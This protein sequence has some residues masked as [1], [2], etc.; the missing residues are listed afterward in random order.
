MT[1]N[2]YKIVLTAGRTL[3]SEYHQAT[4]LG[5]SSTMPRGLIPDEMFF[6][7]LVPSV[8]V[9]G[10][11]S[12][13]SA[14]LGQRKIE[15]ALL[16]Y[17]YSRD[18]VIVA[19]PDYLDRVVGPNTRVLGLTEHD[20]LGLG[21][22]TST[23]SQC[24]GGEPYNFSKFKEILAHPN[25]AKY[26]PKIILGGGG[27]WQFKN[28]KT[29]D[30]YSIHCVCI[31]EGDKVIGPLCDKAIAGEELPRVVYGRM[32]AVNEIPLIRG[33]TICG[34]IEI[35]R[36]C[37]R[38]CDFCVPDMLR[39]R[40][41]PV[42]D[43]LKEVEVNVATGRQ[44]LLH[45]EDVL[46]Y[47]APTIKVNGEAVSNLFKAV[48]AYPGVKSVGISHFCLASAYSAPEVVEEVSN[49]LNLGDNNGQ[50][51]ISG[52]TGVET[53]S[54]RMVEKHMTGKVKPFKAEEWP[55]V[56]VGAFDLLNRHHWVPAGTILIG[57]PE[58]T[59]RD[60]EKTIDMVKRLR[61]YKSVLVPMFTVAT[62]PEYGQSFTVDRMTEMQGELF[63]TC[64]EHDAAWAEKLVDEYITDADKATADGIR[65]V[66]SLSVG[67]ITD[68]INKCRREYHCNIPAMIKDYKEL[69][70]PE[71]RQ[72]IN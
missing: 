33:P 43:I 20:P 3:M 57:L 68:I 55:D 71:P 61:N 5:F 54:P 50:L 9:N 59:D 11:G 60:V 30:E 22:P 69:Y 41:R 53:G 46:R 47:G 27:A 13:V 8:D 35:A 28:P 19:H 40:Y 45:S 39:V 17:G 1:G 44:P 66:I 56:V 48:K 65:S 12:V 34:L 4:F 36:G 49:I 15:A 24:I 2:G 31:G 26:K 10:D 37:G 38:G 25:V 23:F 62:D 32:A 67:A 58:E 51:W 70:G 63:L 7:Y 6:T 14:Q 29:Q 21:P 64:W 18:D 52:Q 42:E 16:D 72:V